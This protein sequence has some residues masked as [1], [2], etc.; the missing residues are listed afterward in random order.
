MKLRN[1]V[2]S[3]GSTN[4]LNADATRTVVSFDLL[5]IRYIGFIYNQRSLPHKGQNE[6][7]SIIT[8][9]KNYINIS[10]FLKTE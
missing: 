1:S 9:P 5:I 10:T 3:I 2:L 7:Y 6:M 8:M 4:T